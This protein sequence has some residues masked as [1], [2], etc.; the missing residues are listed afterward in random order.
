MRRAGEREIEIVKKSAT[1]GLATASV[2]PTAFLLYGLI[3]GD[4]SSPIANYSG[5]A[6]LFTGLRIYYGRVA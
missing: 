3:S 5:S 4:H 2:L 6:S 1:S